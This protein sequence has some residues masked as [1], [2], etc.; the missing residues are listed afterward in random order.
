MTNFLNCILLKVSET[1][2]WGFKKYNKVVSEALV[3]CLTCNLHLHNFS[4]FLSYHS[5]T[6]L[7]VADPTCSLA[8]SI[9][10]SCSPSYALHHLLCCPPFSDLLHPLFYHLFLHL[11]I[12][13]ITAAFS[14]LSPALPSF[15]LSL[16]KSKHHILQP[17]SSLPPSPAL[18]S[19]LLLFT[20][21]THTLLSCMQSC[22]SFT[23]T[24]CGTSSCALL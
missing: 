6:Q 16:H 12:P 24:R 18:S 15:S 7:F 8:S 9:I 10:Y 5:L 3:I 23:F 20:C 17:A 19:S 1:I 21:L 14:C 11:L 22:W 4:F 2:L 13:Y